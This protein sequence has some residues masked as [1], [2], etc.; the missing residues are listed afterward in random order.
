MF[1]LPGMRRLVAVLLMMA[2]LS[3]EAGPTPLPASTAVPRP[4]EEARKMQVIIQVSPDLASALHKR[5]SPTIESKELLSFIQASGLTLKP[6]HPDT[7]DLTLL[8]YFV[9]EVPDQA[10]AQRVVE[11]LQQFAGV[12]A[13]YVKP[14]DELP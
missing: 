7:E 8:N 11:H 14:P 9:V 12:E 6:M 3:C 13:A 10:T 2:C 1:S 4:S 5:V